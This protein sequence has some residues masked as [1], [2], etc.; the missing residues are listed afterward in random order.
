MRRDTSETCPE[1]VRQEVP[2][3]VLAL[4]AATKAWLSPLARSNYD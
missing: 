4:P 2:G 3:E 1:H